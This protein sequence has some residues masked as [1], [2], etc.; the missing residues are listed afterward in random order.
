MGIEPFERIV[1]QIVR[2]DARYAPDAYHFVREAL[3]FTTQSLKKPA[4]GPGR[5]V[6]AAELLE[7]IRRFAL[8]EYGAMALTVLAD[9]GIRRCSDFGQIVFHLVDR[10]VLGKTDED[11]IRDFNG[12]YDFD[13]AF[14]APFRPEP[15]ASPRSL[16]P[17]S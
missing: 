3:D 13:T 5:H 14:R 7:G 1:D 2:R 12:G 16:K 17:A 8:R 4:T 6:S 9:W 11:S 15:R 10:H